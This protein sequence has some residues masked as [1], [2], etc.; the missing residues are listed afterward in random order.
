MNEIDQEYLEGTSISPNELHIQY[1][2]PHEEIASFRN[3][4]R[5]YPSPSVIIREGDQDHAL[6]LL[7][8]GTVEV[9]MGQGASKESLGTIEAV[10]FL[11]EMSLINDEARSAT[12]AS[13][14]N[15]VVIYKIPNPNI[16]GIL[17]NPK[18]SELLISRLARNLAKSHEQY[19]EVV[20]QSK[21]LR[22]E[23]DLI[24]AEMKSLKAEMKSRQKESANNARLAFNGILHFQ[25]IIQQTAV[26]GSKGWAYLN[27]LN[28]ITQSLIAHYFS[29]LDETNKNV[30]KNVIHE[31]LLALPQD[32]QHKIIEEL[33]QFI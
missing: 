31:C 28:R 6:Y 1:G 25:N 5:V 11:G 24:E 20:K 3:F 23:L 22:S 7:R 15:N 12:V 16:Q 8:V 4:I 18:W 13:S 17:S 29:D 27:V 10:N 33:K 21:V 30:E 14:T 19:I 26:V 9:F 2:I 32:E